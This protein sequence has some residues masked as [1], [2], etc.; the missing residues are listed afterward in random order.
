MKATVKRTL[1]LLL[2]TILMF[3]LAACGGGTS[4]AAE[5]SG[6]EPVAAPAAEPA[7]AEE[8]DAE[9]AEGGYDGEIVELDFMNMDESWKVP[10]WGNDPTTQKFMEETGVKFNCI[11]PQGQWESVANV[12]LAAGDYPDMMHMNVTALYNQYVAAGALL[13]INKLAEEYGYPQIMDGTYIPEAAINARTS[14]DGNLYLVPNWF[15]DDGFGSVGTAINIRNDVYEQLGKPPLTTIDELYAYLVSIRD[16]NLTSPD[17]AKMWPFTFE[18]ANKDYIGYITNLWGHKIF[19]FNYF[20]EAANDVKFMLR[21]P[22]L[23]ESLS[24]MSR[25]L[26][27]GLMDPEALTYDNNTQRESHNQLKHAVVYSEVWTLWTP[28][29]ALRQIDPNM[30]FYAVEPPRGNPDREPWAGR[31]HKSGGSGTMI[32]KNCRDPEA[33]MRFINYF[34]SPEGETLNFYGVEGNTMEFVDGKPQLYPEAYE[35]KLADWDGYAHSHGVRIFDMMNNQVYNWERDQESEDRQIDRAKA[36]EFAF[37]GTIQQVAL[38]DPMSPE[39]IL[40]AEIEANIQSELVKIIMEPDTSKIPAMVDELL[41]EYE[42]KGVA[43]L[44]AEWT[45]QYLA[46]M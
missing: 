10:T 35:A 30:F 43:S 11:A 13:P 22:D 36:A 17:G 27:E 3:S 28:Q 26:S 8:P 2:A 34:L 18:G 20:D 19:R 32:T 7:A 38:V 21:E 42:R 39:G 41:A 29:S 9:S 31:I 5:T 37:D 12:M 4:P 14:D 16:A 46:R 45:K 33:A 1:S 23:K 6:E 40:L 44:E 24:F 15:S 25:L